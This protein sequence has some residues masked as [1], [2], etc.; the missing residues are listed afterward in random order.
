MAEAVHLV[1]DGN[2][3]GMLALTREDIRR[4]YE[5]YG[6]PPE[7]V[8]GKMTKKKVSWTIVDENLMLDEKKQVLYS[9][10]MHIDSNK[11]LI[12]VCEPLQLTIQNRIEREMQNELGMALQSQLNLLRSRGFVPTV[13][14]MDLQSAFHAFVGQFPEVVI[15]IGG[16]GDYVSKWMPKFGES[17]NYIGVPR[18]A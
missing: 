5:I 12:T 10:V 6:S 1:E 9:D 16:A 8:R 17:R 15:D 4:A 11:F 3:S 13:V 7:F 18:Q 14:H 2:I